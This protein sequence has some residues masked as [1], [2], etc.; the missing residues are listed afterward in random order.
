MRYAY[1]PG[2]SLD[3]SARD[4]DES[5]RAVLAALGVELEEL[6]DWNC[7]GG[8]AISSVEPDLALAFSARNLAL[9]EELHLDLATSCAACYTNLRRA[10]A[11]VTGKTPAGERVRGALAEVNRH[12]IGTAQV[13]HILE[14]LLTD[15]GIKTIKAA[16]KAPLNGV[17]VAAYYGCQLGRPAGGFIHPEIPTQMDELIAALGASPVDW[18]GKVR[19]CGASTMITKEEAA[20]GLVDEL[21]SDAEKAGAQI[22]ATACPL[23]QMNLDAYQPRINRLTGKQHKLPVVYFTQL[24]EIALGLTPKFDFNFVGVREVLK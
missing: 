3:S 11:V 19:C 8:G 1:F 16:V 14:I 10:R 15:V 23:C 5:A 9:A 2:C 20:S 18:R 12:L 24:M 4:Y 21:L 7:C 17:K 13:R 22:I 6:K